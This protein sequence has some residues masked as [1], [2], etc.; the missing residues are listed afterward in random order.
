MSTSADSRA[1][2]TETA[3][4]VPVRDRYVYALSEGDAGM[5]A[6]LGAKC[7]GVAEMRRIGVP[8]PDGF[9]VTTAAC[10]AAMRRR[11]EWPERLWDE[12]QE[13][14]AA[15]EQRRGRTWATST[16]RCSCRYGPALRDPCPA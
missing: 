4:P 5:S 16:S 13:H 7:A 11:G 6:L 14:V 1:A 8:V 15:L 9:T 2:A 12:I 10:V 3:P